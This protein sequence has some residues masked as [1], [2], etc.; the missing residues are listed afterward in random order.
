MRFFSILLLSLTLSFG[1]LAGETQKNTNKQQTKE[2]TPSKARFWTWVSYS[3]KRDWDAYFTELKR[4]G[5]DGIL[6]SS[7][8]EGY[9]KVI[10]IAQKYGIEVQA[11]LWVMNNGGIA[12]EHPEW[13]DYNALGHSLKD[14]MAYVGY[15]KFLNPI[16]PGVREKI[17]TNFHNIAKIE[18][19]SGVS[20]D[21]C[22]Y[23]DAILPYHLWGSYGIVQD[24]IYPKW[25]YGYHP[26]MVETFID[27]HGYD[28]R[29]LVDTTPG[30]AAPDDKKWLKFRLETLNTLVDSIATLIHSEGKLFTASPFPTPEMSKH[31]VRQDWGK[32]PLDMA[33]AM[34]YQGFYKDAGLEWIAQ[35][36][37]ECKRD[38][39]SK[40]RIF[41]GMHI[42]DFNK[43]DSP[44]L[45]DAVNTALENGAEGFSMYTFDALNP[46]QREE[47]RVLIE[48]IKSKDKSCCSGCSH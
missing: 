38:L 12:N 29:E 31:M 15:Y 26:A 8:I 9:K 42:P 1:A 20:F 13:L 5:L 34:I 25:D 17:A 37:R 3:D 30:A 28:P 10:P 27:K 45:T 11:W 6:M 21:Y 16:I 24:K 23:V 39:K 4:V 2:I 7:G 18:G 33:F 14:S 35:C 19:L 47:L 43:K 36:V 44:S 46:E 41:L 22:R 40:G 32:W 48:D